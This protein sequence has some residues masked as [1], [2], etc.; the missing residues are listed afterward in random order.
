MLSSLI[1]TL[2][3]IQT[4]EMVS[5]ISS[6]SYDIDSPYV[7]LLFRHSADASKFYDLIVFDYPYFFEYE[8][9]RNDCVIKL[10]LDWE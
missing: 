1:D 9:S 4:T 7:E 6:I 5:S 8:P 2:E 3:F 10:W